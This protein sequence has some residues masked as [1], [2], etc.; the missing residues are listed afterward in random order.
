M[1]VF[2][3]NKNEVI[4][5][6]ANIDFIPEE[7]FKLVFARVA[8]E[9]DKKT[10]KKLIFDKRNLKIFDQPSMVWYHIVWKATVKAKNGMITHRKLLPNNPDFHLSVDIGKAHI[11]LTNPDFDFADFDIQYVDTL[12]DALAR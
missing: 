9:I 1:N 8:Q 4:F 6:I 10:I 5:C 12:E 2:F 3:D 7:D 11:Q